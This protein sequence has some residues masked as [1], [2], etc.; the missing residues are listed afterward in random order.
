MND[1]H[2]AAFD[3][4]HYSFGNNISER[5]RKKSFNRVN[6]FGFGLIC[7]AY[8]ET[9]TCGRRFGLLSRICCFCCAIE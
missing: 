7:I 3:T 4:S 9:S 8:A 5:N 1:G 6:L 2:A